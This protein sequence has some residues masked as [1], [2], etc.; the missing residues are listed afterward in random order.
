[1][2]I[3]I[4]RVKIIILVMIIIE[5]TSNNEISY[6][7]LR[8]DDDINKIYKLWDKFVNFLQEETAIY[9]S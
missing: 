7:R 1:M 3:V 5:N 4:L 6:T 8:Q 9:I 2:T